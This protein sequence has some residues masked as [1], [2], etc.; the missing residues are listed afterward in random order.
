MTTSTFTPAVLADLHRRLDRVIATDRLIRMLAAR[1]EISAAMVAVENLRP[2][3]LGIELQI[4][5]AGD[6]KHMLDQAQDAM[7]FLGNW[8][9]DEIPSQEAIAQHV[10]SSERMDQEQ[11]PDCDPFPDLFSDFIPM[12]DPEDETR[13]NAD[14]DGDYERFGVCPICGN[15]N[16]YLNIRKDHFGVCHNHK[17]I[18]SIG[19]NIFSS[20]KDE[21]E[22]IWKKNRETLEQYEFREPVY[23]WKDA[24]MPESQDQEGGQ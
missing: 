24:S 13:V 21:D 7:H 20:W 6:I 4:E 10:A 17:I 23:R 12:D 16:G 2:L 9:K 1:G 22:T 18:W 8:L 5:E 15:S 3:L 11:P 19:Y 14:E